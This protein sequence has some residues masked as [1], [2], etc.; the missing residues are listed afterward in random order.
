[1]LKKIFKWIG[2][3]IGSLL[4]LVLL[5]LTT[6]YFMTEIRANKIWEIKVQKLTIPADSASLALGAHVAAIRGC[7]DCHV[8]G[9]VPFFDDKNPIAFLH[10]ANLT[11]GLGG[12]NYSD[13]DWL[14]ALRHG[15]GKNGKSLWFMPVQHTS[16]ALSNK[17]LGALICYLKQLPPIDNVHPKKVMKPLGRVLTFLGIFPMFPAEQVN[18]L[19]VYPDEVKPEA[20]ADYGAYLVMGCKGCHGNNYKGNAAT[21]PG[22]PPIPDLTTTGHLGKWNS[23]QFI[24]ALH[25][26]KTP[27]GHTLSGFMPWST[28]GKA[29]TDEELTAL[30]LYLHQLK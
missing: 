2:I 27:D 5:F 26:G 4:I 29:H 18:H 6:A 7:M 8:K 12:I 3:A 16:A 24:T 10:S 19:T 22:E 21:A 23:A 28:V 11:N 13:E 20:T 30:Y 17:E 14:R 25:T 1:M 9:G 15:V